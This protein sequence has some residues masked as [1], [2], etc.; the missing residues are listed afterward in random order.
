VQVVLDLRLLPQKLLRL[1]PRLPLQKLLPM[2]LLLRPP[3]QR[4]P[5]LLVLLK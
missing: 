2:R 1:L 5:H 3:R 4:L